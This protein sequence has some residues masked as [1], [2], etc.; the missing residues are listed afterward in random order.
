[1]IDNRRRRRT[2]ARERTRFGG[3][4]RPGNRD[5][6]RYR[7][8]RELLVREVTTLVLWIAVASMLVHLASTLRNVASVHLAERSVFIR[9]SLPLVALAGT[10]FC[11]W[12]ARFNWREVREIQA[13]QSA[14]RQRL[15]ELV[16]DD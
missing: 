6:I 5:L 4:A 3:S 10:V 2:S 7:R 14:T 13:D 1:L 12:R 11:F 15:E 16:D 8:N 9:H